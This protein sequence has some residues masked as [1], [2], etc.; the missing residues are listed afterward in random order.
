MNEEKLGYFTLHYLHS[1]SKKLIITAHGRKKGRSWYNYFPCCCCYTGYA[2]IPDNTKFI[3]L[4]EEGTS[5]SNK[6]LGAVAK[7]I[8]GE[9]STIFI[10]PKTYVDTIQNY[11]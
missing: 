3:M 5:I 1:R 10:N 7:S 6:G 11:D 2:Y 4:A 9:G 8:V